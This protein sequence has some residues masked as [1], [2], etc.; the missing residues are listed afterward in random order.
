MRVA[1]FPLFDSWFRQS[2]YARKYKSREVWD[3]A[4]SV[5]ADADHIIAMTR[6][7]YQA[8]VKEWG[9]ARMEEMRLRR[10]SGRGVRRGPAGN[11]Q[12]WVARRTVTK[13]PGVTRCRL[14][15]KILTTSPGGRRLHG[16][17]GMCWDTW[18][19][20]PEYR[21]KWKQR[22][23]GTVEHGA[24]IDPTMPRWRGHPTTPEGLARKYGWLIR[25]YLLRQTFTS[26][27]EED[28]VSR[29][30]VTQGVDDLVSWLPSDL[31]CAF[32]RPG[33]RKAIE[34][35]LGQRRLTDTQ[36]E[37]ESRLILWLGRRWSMAPTPIARLVV[38]FSADDIARVLENVA[39]VSER[40]PQQGAA[41]EGGSVSMRGRKSLSRARSSGGSSRPRWP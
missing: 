4:G 10:G 23:W 15:T 14:C 34:R 25:H 31:A 21:A 24:P 5:G 19:R 27:A 9:R 13:N 11:F 17:E 41:R 32:P 3:G 29:E 30:A 38:G 18:R 36:R 7:I 40:K 35:A 8:I 33:M 1:L 39:L 22:R 6:T 28:G 2:K 16:G 12:Q 26:I 37:E 20:S